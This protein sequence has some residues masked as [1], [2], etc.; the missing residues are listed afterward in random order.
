MIP[1]FYQ[2]TS[3]QFSYHGTVET[4]CAFFL[5][6][7]DA[8][9][10]A[11]RRHGDRLDGYGDVCVFDDYVVYVCTFGEGNLRCEIARYAYG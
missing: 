4:H 8:T 1:R 5:T 6:E 7:D 11:D 9:E 2:V 3:E 10:Y